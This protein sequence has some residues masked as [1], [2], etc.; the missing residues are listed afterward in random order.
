M[1]KHSAGWWAEM[2]RV[3]A[4]QIKLREDVRYVPNTGQPF[5]PNP[6]DNASVAESTGPDTAQHD[7][8]VGW[9]VPGKTVCITVGPVRLRYSTDEA[10]ALSRQL[11]Y[12]LAEQQRGQFTECGCRADSAVDSPG[13]GPR[14]DDTG[15]TEIEPQRGAAGRGFWD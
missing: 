10:T 4:E 6:G 7:D 9:L 8:H 14:S 2:N 15:D 5:G 3:A 11:H 1:T 13:A 12:L